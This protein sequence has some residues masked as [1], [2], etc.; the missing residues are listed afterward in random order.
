MEIVLLISSFFVWL[1]V[2]SSNGRPRGAR[3][4]VAVV[5]EVY[6]AFDWMNHGNV[7]QQATDVDLHRLGW[8]GGRAFVLRFEL[9]LTNHL[10]NAVLMWK[11]NSRCPVARV[12]NLCV[13]MYRFYLLYRFAS[14]CQNN[15]GRYITRHC[16]AWCVLLIPVCINCLPA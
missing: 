7:L 8:R 16:I 2:E 15:L 9:V 14:E 6:A 12:T 1:T 5:T 3:N 10:R 11:S 4:T 13:W